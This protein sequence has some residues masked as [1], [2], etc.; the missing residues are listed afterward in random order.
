M[1]LHLLDNTQP[2]PQ[3]LEK[4]KTQLFI[5]LLQ[6]QT[7]IFLTTRFTS[8]GKAVCEQ[9]IVLKE[10]PPQRCNLH[11]PLEGTPARENLAEVDVA[12]VRMVPSPPILLRM[13]HDLCDFWLFFTTLSVHVMKCRYIYSLRTKF[14]P[15][16]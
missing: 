9:Q 3:F 14:T 15:L 16:L 10:V 13:N 4:V 12:T 11:W 1:K 7:R 2:V 5:I 6:R 8:R